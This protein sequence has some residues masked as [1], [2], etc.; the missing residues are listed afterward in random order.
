[1]EPHSK[2]DLGSQTEQGLPIFKKRDQMGQISIVLIA[3]LIVLFHEP[4]ENIREVNELLTIV[5]TVGA[6]VVPAILVYFSG[7]YAARTTSTDVEE[8][9][10]RLYLFK[11]TA[12]VFEILLL[13][14]YVCEI[15]LL[16]L[17]LLIHQRLQFLPFVNMRQTLAIIPLIVGLMLIRVALYEIDQL[18]LRQRWKRSELLSF[19]LKFL[20]LPLMPLFVYLAILD[21]IVLL[22]TGVK[23]F[24]IEHVYLLIA[25]AAMLILSAY[26]Y[27]PLLLGLIWKTVPL[28]HPDLEARLHRLAERDGIKYKNIVVWQTGS[29]SIANAAVA[30]IAPWARKIFLTDALM[31]RFTVEEIETIVA[32]EFGHIR[33]KHLLTYLLFWLTYFLG[34]MLFYLYIVAPIESALPESSILPSIVTI[35][36]FVFYFV[37]VFRYLSRRFEHQ[38]DL[39]AVRLTGNPEVFKS[40]LSRLALLNYFPKSIRRLFEVFHTHP[41]IHRRIAFIDWLATKDSRVLRYQHYLLEAKIILALIPMLAGILFFGNWPQLG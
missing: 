1:M 32:H 15:H 5:F 27:A 41:S 13:V 14:G 22:P 34:H 3:G 2:L 23:A 39:Y 11:R 25:L 20:L 4:P 33:Y 35:A 9:V 26:V 19:H 6:T 31:R 18:V 8:Q 36:F 24:F 10:R 21:L 30:G 16:N 7:S 12:I 28:A 40:A 37:F 38:A 17:P 29:L